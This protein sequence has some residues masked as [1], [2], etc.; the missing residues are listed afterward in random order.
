MQSLRPFDIIPVVFGQ[1][2]YLNV[3]YELCTMFATN[4]AMGNVQLIQIYQGEDSE[5]GIF[6]PSVLEK[7]P[8]FRDIID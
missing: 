5:S 4:A 3:W 6:S 7:I 2:R 8:L 1:R